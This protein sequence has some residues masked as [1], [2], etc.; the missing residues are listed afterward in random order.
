MF[1]VCSHDGMKRL[2]MN[3]VA[4]HIERALSGVPLK[5]LADLQAADRAKRQAA[6]VKLAHH[7]AYELRDCDVFVEAAAEWLKMLPCMASAINKTGRS[8]H[9]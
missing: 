1:F 9:H 2:T 4:L 7:V 3:N 5:Q 6:V 8:G